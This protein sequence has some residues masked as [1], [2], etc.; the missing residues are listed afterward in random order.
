MQQEYIDIA[1]A[2]ALAIS[3]S[4]YN[5]GF[6]QGL[7]LGIFIAFMVYIKVSG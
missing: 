6:A 3:D 4:F 2:Q 1:T 7:A 5:L